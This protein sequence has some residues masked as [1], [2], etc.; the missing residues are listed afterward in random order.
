M[1]ID[2]S[3]IAFTNNTQS[4]DNTFNIAEKFADIKGALESLVY[5]P[6][7]DTFATTDVTPVTLELIVVAS[8]PTLSG[9]A[10]MAIRRRNTP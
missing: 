3:G 4:G 10:L 7:D 8:L 1:K 6:P 5:E 2:A 9:G